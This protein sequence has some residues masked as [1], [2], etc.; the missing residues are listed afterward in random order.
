M[1]GPTEWPNRPKILLISENKNRKRGSRF[2]G[3]AGVCP[4]RRMRID[5]YAP[6]EC[7]R[8]VVRAAST[9]EPYCTR[10]QPD[11]TFPG[12]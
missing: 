12:I 5:A 8:T 4:Y 7:P 11:F 10:P 9:A 3:S 6:L 2:V 1:G